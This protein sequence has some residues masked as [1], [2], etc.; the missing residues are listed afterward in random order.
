MA[1]INHR[2]NPFIFIIA[3]N[4]SYYTILIITQFL[5]HNS[6]TQFLILQSTKYQD[7]HLGQR[8]K[9]KYL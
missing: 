3:T 2:D 4:Y 7:K 6:I 9:H 5:L 8:N 1:A